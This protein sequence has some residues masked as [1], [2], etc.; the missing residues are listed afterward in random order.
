MKFFKTS[1]PKPLK[2]KRKAL[3]ESGPHD[4]T[5]PPKTIIEVD[6]TTCKIRGN[7]AA[8][9]N[10]F[11][12]PWLIG[13]CISLNYHIDTFV[14]EWQGAERSTLRYIENRKRE[15]GENY[16][17]VT[18]NLRHIEW[19]N[20]IGPDEKM[21]FREYIHFRYNHNE[22][23]SE[24]L[25]LDII[26][27]LIHA[28][29]FPGLLIWGIGFKRRGPL[30]FDRKRRLVLFWYVG[31]SCVQRYDDLEIHETT[32]GLV[33]ILRAVH[34]KTGELKYLHFPVQ[35]GGNPLISNPETYQP[36]LSFIVKF[37]E[38]GLEKVLPDGPYKKTNNDFLLIEDK[39]PDDF[40]EK[41]KTVLAMLDE[42]KDLK[43][44]DV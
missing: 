34:P 44:A 33:F 9:R 15:Y 14:E 26:W 3:L 29:A 18:T 39:K 5:K 4:Y 7:F 1:D 21:S 12:I 17:S 27:G 11:I 35:P 31:K 41:I 22:Y 20:R 10:L 38:H 32:D 25:I 23:S 24:I 36:I 40:E 37:M 16:F 8:F 43:A 6:K 19:Y 13:V 2:D 28:I 42:K 30:I